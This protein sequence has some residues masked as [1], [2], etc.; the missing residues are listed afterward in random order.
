MRKRKRF[1]SVV[2]IILAL[3][4]I[5]TLCLSVLV[6]ADAVSQSEIDALKTKQSAIEQQ[7][8][9]LKSKMSGLESQKSSAT[10]QKQQL[11][12]Q[13]QLAQSEIDNINQQ[14]ALY[15]GLIRQK[16]QELQAATDNAEKQKESLRVRMRAMEE[17]GSLT[18]FAI[19]FDSNSFSD[20]LSRLDFVSTIMKYD[21]NLET[22]Y[23][24]A[25]Q[26]ASD[27]KTEYEQTQ[28]QQKETRTELIT[29]KT[30]LE[31]QVA[32]AN[33]LIT[34]LE[35]NISDYK[36]EYEE[37]ESQEKEINS[38]ITK[39][40]AELQKQQEEAKKQGKTVVTG[41]GKWTW[42]VPASHTIT[43]PFGW[44]V[45]PIFGDSRFHSGIDIAAPY[46]STIMAADAGTV[47]SAVYSSSYGNYVVISH[48]NSTTSLYAHMSSMAVSAGQTVSRGQT[49]GYVGSTGWSTGCH[50]HFEVRIN[51]T[52]VD[53]ESLF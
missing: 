12:E 17:S 30:D 36:S 16:A 39:K 8:K 42:P 53:P 48:G 27:A 4:F 47:V 18:Y 24:S 33:D 35:Q 32:K 38:E 2:C 7:Q 31:N 13:N 1:I 26:Q 9:S 21:Q 19:L 44:R 51:G 22:S 50:C 23:I 45:H 37:S 20:L 10:Q 34:Q 25:K 43:S 11:D 52:L 49:I 46:G 6:K 41:S 29:K 40:V 3:I 15:D 28:T 14:I 5:V